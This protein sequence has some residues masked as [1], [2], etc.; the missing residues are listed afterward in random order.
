MRPA[1]LETP[2]FNAEVL[3]HFLPS[4]LRPTYLVA[5]LIHRAFRPTPARPPR[6]SPSTL[7]RPRSVNSKVGYL[8]LD[9]IIPSSPLQLEL[10]RTSLFICSAAVRIASTRYPSGS[11]HLGSAR[12]R[13]SNSTATLVCPQSQPSSFRHIRFSRVAN[14]NLIF[15]VLARRSW[16][17]L[18]RSFVRSLL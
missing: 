14:L 7:I 18:A 4:F 16:L 12:P 6:K 13:H 15:S 11:P 5:Q 17:P 2:L 8:W 10:Q 9:A 3:S 1:P